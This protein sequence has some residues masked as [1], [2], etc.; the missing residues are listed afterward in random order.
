MEYKNPHSSQFDHIIELI[1]RP[2]RHKDLDIIL[3][4]HHSYEQVKTT[5]TRSVFTNLNKDMMETYRKKRVY[6]DCNTNSAT[7][8]CHGIG[9]ERPILIIRALQRVWPD[10]S[11]PITLRRIVIAYFEEHKS[12]KYAFK[13]K[14]CHG[15]EK[16]KKL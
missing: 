8:G 6:E 12:T 13:C 9:E 11:K 3:T 15:A 10:R 2:L 7:A 14:P 5:F 1:S 16:K 4:E